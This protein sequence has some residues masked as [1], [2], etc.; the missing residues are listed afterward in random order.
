MFNVIATIT[1]AANPFNGRRVVM[2]KN[3]TREEAETAIAKYF[4]G[5]RSPMTIEAA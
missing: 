4:K 1:D 3:V 2:L 5:L